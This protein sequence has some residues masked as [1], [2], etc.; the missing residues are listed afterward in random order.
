M[1]IIDD[2]DCLPCADTYHRHFGSLRN[3]FSLIGHTAER[4]Y[5][6]VDEKE[7]WDE[8]TINLMREIAATLERLG[9]Q[10]VVESSDD[11]LRIDGKVGVLFR[12]ARSFLRK[13]HLT[14]SRVP[15]LRKTPHRWIVAIRLTDDNKSVRMIPAK[16]LAEKHPRRCI[17]I[18]DQSRDRLGFGR[19]ET[20]EALAQSIHCEIRAQH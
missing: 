12:V 15:R 20:A 8:V 10:V 11:Q 18:T 6:F 5:A 4:N 13:G 1:A 7:V 17:T 9:R 16:G 3:A 14:S 2:T 19:F